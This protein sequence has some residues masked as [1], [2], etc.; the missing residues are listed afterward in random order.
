MPVPTLRHRLRKKFRS[1]A[2][3]D[4]LD[5]ITCIDTEREVHPENAGLYIDEVEAIWSA[6]KDVYR[7]GAH[8]LLSICLRRGG[9]IVLNRTICLLYTSDAAD[10]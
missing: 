4:S 10:D 3:P 9:D 1:I 2:L 5:D 7:T 8:P 6:A